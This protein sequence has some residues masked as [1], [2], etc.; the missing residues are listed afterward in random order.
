ME[1][2]RNHIAAGTELRLNGRLDGQWAGALESEL[3][4][5]IR[6]GERHIQLN[7][8]EVV[9]LSSAGIRVLLKQ[10]KALQSIGGMLGVVEPSPAVRK[11]LEL[12]G[13]AS[14]ILSAADGPASTPTMVFMRRMEHLSL[15]LFTPAAGQ[16]LS[17][18]L[19]G[20]PERLPRLDFRESDMHP[21]A[22]PRN[23]MAL[24][25]G[26]LA[27]DFADAQPRFGEFLAVGG[28]VLH[29]PTDGSNV[30]DYML[31][32]GEFVP[33]VQALYGVAC[34]G[35]FSHFAQF[36]PAEAGTPET[37]GKTPPAAVAFS[38]LVRAAF[39]V[40]KADTLALVLLAETTGLTGASLKSSPAQVATDSRKDL[41]AHPEVRHWLA[42]TPER[43]YAR[44]LALVAG[45]ATR[46]ESPAL[47]PFVRPLAPDAPVR[48]HFHAAAFPYRA[49]S[50]G[51]LILEET[52]SNLF[53]SESVLGLLHLLHDDRAYSGAGESEFTRGS[54]W[55][56]P[57]HL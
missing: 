7:L 41:F 1:I 30:P 24:G 20:E 48:G 21:L 40:V 53:E 16:A 10:W 28:A 42:F 2:L 15:R 18:R 33:T 46:V 39:E 12:S 47:S 27:R 55:A 50:K 54:F 52:V 49:Q 44:N 23:T 5:L 8:A 6:S 51:L 9:F 29:L 14:L 57:V 45:I 43:A 38:D 25:L 35:R 4:E 32:H 31:A 56:G 36:E 17:C 34:Q 37:G 13:L 11:T 26:A 3:Q 19:L 22:V